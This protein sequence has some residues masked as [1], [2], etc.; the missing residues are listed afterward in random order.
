MI[1]AL[2]VTTLVGAALLTGNEFAVGAFIHPSL[3]R[4]ETKTHVAAVREIGRVC[5]KVMPFWMGGVVLFC[6][7]LVWLS[8]PWFSQICWFFA[9]AA[10]FYAGAIVFSLLGP[11]PINNK[12]VK[13]NSDDLPGDWREL[14]RR[15]D[16]LHSV[17]IAILIIGF[18]CLVTGVM[19]R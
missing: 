19:L 15:W 5:G 9:A 8:A 13:W 7:S 11:V 12:V 6:L 2:I 17:R 1:E 18:I 4:L 3:S 16:N 10:A 14:R